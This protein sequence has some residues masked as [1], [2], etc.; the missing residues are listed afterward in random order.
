MARKIVKMLY[1]LMVGI[2]MYFTWQT[3]A[4]TVLSSTVVVYGHVADICINRE[5]ISCSV[6][7]Q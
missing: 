7:V 1:M 2:H 6:V 4:R 5:T 3:D